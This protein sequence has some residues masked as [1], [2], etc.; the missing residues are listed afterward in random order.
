MRLAFR[1]YKITVG[2]KNFFARRIGLRDDKENQSGDGDKYR[3]YNCVF[4]FHLVNFQP[5]HSKYRKQDD[6]IE[7]RIPTFKTLQLT[8][9]SLRLIKSTF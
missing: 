1:R 7:N 6:L 4:C 2:D 5:K 9:E 3:A 8:G